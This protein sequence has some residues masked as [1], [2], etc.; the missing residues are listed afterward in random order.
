MPLNDGT[1][2]SYR[3]TGD[4]YSKG[5]GTNVVAPGYYKVTAKDNIGPGVD[6][7]LLE[8][9][10][11]DSHQRIVH[12]DDA[13]VSNVKIGTIYKPGETIISYPTEVVWAD[14]STHQ[15]S[16]EKFYFKKETKTVDDEGNETWSIY[17]RTDYT[18]VRVY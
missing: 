8:R 7:I 1:F 14:T 4:D 11:T 16:S 9:I 17:K 6:R 18:N 2:L 10:G 5:T 12:L 3:H 13:D 15:P